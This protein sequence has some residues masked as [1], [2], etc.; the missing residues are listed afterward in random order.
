M[1]A[2]VI[3]DY[4]QPLRES[5]VPEPVVGERDVLVDVGAAGVNQ[6]DEKLR[7]G[8]FKQILPY[9]MPLVLG[10]DVAGTVVRTG[11]QVQGFAPGDRVYARPRDHR[12]GTFAER[13]AVDEADLAPAPAS[14]GLVE[15][16]SL[17]LV[18]LTAWQALVVKGQVKPGQRVLIHAGAGGVGSIAI[19]LAKHL[20]A[21]VAT[22]ASGK[23]ADF[24][25]DLGAD[26]VIDY[27]AQDFE[28][29][30]AGY[31]LVL[32]SLGGENLEKSL[33]VLRPG[34]KAIGI[35]GPPDPAFAREQ[36]MNPLLRLAIA[37][38]SR[39]IRKQ[40][41]RA[42]VTYEFLFMTADGAQL[43]EVAD[44][45]DQGV[46]RPVVG[47]TFPFAQTPQALEAL[48]RGGLRGKVVVTAA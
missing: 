28:Q 25:R 10:H 7:T 27:R 29:E 33:R 39:K 35:S 17:P 4:K 8:E 34:G 46:L 31:D 12:I 14:V 2:F 3:D 42:G 20:G 21:H 16:A 37:A 15:A 9:A 44:L 26:V 13:I 23:N 22:T 6:L 18:A 30:L 47:Q 40:A 24:V 43:R 41:K 45:V 5:E 11:A 48:T 38:L 1:R 19:Q 32:D 36:G